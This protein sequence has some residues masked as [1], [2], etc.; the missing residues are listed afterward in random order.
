MFIS[1]SIDL[2]LIPYSAQPTGYRTH[3]TQFSVPSP[4]P[5]RF[6]QHALM[7]RPPALMPVSALP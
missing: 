3:V 5:I 4:V 6:C 7:S 1:P 2:F